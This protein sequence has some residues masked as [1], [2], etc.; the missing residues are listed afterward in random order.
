MLIAVRWLGS[1]LDLVLGTQ[2]QS[3]GN[4]CQQ[5][6]ASVGS[7]TPIFGKRRNRRYARKRPKSRWLINGK[8]Q[9]PKSDSTTHGGSDWGNWFVKPDRSRRN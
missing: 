7:A 4:P 9:L 6:T 5:F 2:Q 8:N 1:S 3:F